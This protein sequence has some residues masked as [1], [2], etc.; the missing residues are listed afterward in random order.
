M[1]AERLQSRLNVAVAGAGVVGLACA[2]ELL[3]RGAQV[4]IY[5][6]GPH[7]GAEACSLSLIHI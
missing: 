4:S 6:R 7:I 2:T 3:A 1:T 5:E